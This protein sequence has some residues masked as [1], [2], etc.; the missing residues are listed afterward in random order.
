MPDRTAVGDG[1]AIPEIT[2]YPVI[3][4]EQPRAATKG[5]RIADWG[6]RIGDC[7]L[8][9]ADW[10]CAT[11]V[12]AVPDCGLADARLLM[13]LEFRLTAGDLSDHRAGFARNPSP[14]RGLRTCGMEICAGREE[15][16]R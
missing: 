11:A 15:I 1:S 14:A 6:L 10:S 16:E 5:G 2:G 4:L 8:G 13:A 7:G 9:I 12:S 3:R